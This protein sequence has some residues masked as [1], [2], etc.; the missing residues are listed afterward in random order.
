MTLR[1][2]KQMQAARG[3]TKY[4]GVTSSFEESQISPSDRVRKQALRRAT[5]QLIAIIVGALIV[6]VVAVGITLLI[7]G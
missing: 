4:R 2:L 7:V 3:Q 6:A 1:K 5:N